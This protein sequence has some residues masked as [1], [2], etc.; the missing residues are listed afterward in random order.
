MA[1]TETSNLFLNVI[2]EKN[3]RLL[4]AGSTVRM[5]TERAIAELLLVQFL[6]CFLGIIQ[7]RI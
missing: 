1:G 7:T 2:A 4:S 6:V 5:S 3:I